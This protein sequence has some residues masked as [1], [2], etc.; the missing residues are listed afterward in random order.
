MSLSI[1]LSAP[2]KF[3]LTYPLSPFIPVPDWI[4]PLITPCTAFSAV[5]ESSA[6]EISTTLSAWAKMATAFIPK[7]LVSIYTSSLKLTIASIS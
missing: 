7:P 5:F 4:A 6:L 3:K 1:K 2:V